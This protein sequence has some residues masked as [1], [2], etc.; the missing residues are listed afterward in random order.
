M[1]VADIKTYM[2]DCGKSKIPFLFAIDFSL[3]DGVFIENPI[4]QSDILFRTPLG[5]NQSA[6]D[7]GADSPQ[8]IISPKAITFDEYRHQFDNVMKG[9][10]RGDSYLANLTVKTPIEINIPL[11][12]IFNRSQS[13][14]GIFVADRFVC[15]SPERFVKISN[16]VIST[17]PM[18][19]TINANISDAEK[20]ILDDPKETA[21]H[22]TIVD[23]LRNDL[24]MVATDITVRR[25]R[26]IDRIPTRKGDIL[27]VS[28][29]ITGKLSKDYLSQLGDIIFRML[30]A[31][32]IC[33]APKKSTVEII[34]KA[35]TDSRGFY[36]GIFG[37]FDGNELD[38]AVM[39]RFIEQ[40]GNKYYFHSGGGIT[41]N[42]RA[43]DEYNEVLEKIYLPI[44]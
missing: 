21:E 43:E 16:G 14:Y 39:I 30:P 20:R 23:L 40:E 18:K 19:G 29:E 25:F 33:G 17:N 12:D 15:F 41:V 35:E 24:G 36:T 9:L 2:N 37:Y 3:K 8:P 34:N 31:G 44:Q 11:I 6:F 1:K 10:M 42:S 27:Q 32:S 28:S 5:T 22:C 26:Y 4:S 38:S 13:P 7:T